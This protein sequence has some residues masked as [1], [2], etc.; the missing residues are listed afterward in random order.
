MFFS[1]WHPIYNFKNVKNTHGEV[2]LF[3]VYSKISGQHPIFTKKGTFFEK[4]GHHKI[5]HLPLPAPF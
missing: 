1:I 4:K 5:H 2:L 3:R